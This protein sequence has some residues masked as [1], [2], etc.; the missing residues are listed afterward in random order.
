MS[1]ATRRAAFKAWFVGSLRGDR[2]AFLARTGY[3]KGRLNQFLDPR[4]PFG[5]KAAREVAR[6]VGLAP[7]HFERLETVARAVRVGAKPARPLDPEESEL[8]RLWEPLLVDQKAVLMAELQRQHTLALKTIE[9][10]RRRG[11]DSHAPE[12]VLPP[13]F[14]RPAQRELPELAQ[15][16]GKRRRK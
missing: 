3:T 1:D 13:D 12:D 16:A 2:A 11:Y 9:E 15:A 6:R 5:E 10:I 4:Q 7:D 8:L 14:T